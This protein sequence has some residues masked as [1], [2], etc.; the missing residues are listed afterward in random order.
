MEQMIGSTSSV[1]DAKQPS[2]DRLN[3]DGVE[4]GY[5]EGVGSVEG[6]R[7]TLIQLIYLWIDTP[8]PTALVILLKLKNKYLP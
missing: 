8:S 6:N 7:K 3:L 2:T 5:I 4:A 1:M